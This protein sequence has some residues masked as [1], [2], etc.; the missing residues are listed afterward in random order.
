MIETSQKKTIK[1]CGLGEEAVIGE[2]VKYRR[3]AT[4]NTRRARIAILD[5]SDCDFDL[6]FEISQEFLG[7]VCIGEYD[8]RVADMAE[9][10]RLVGLFSDD[11]A[12][13]ENAVRETAILM[14]ST[15]KAILS[16]DINEL[17]AFEQLALIHTTDT[18]TPRQKKSFFG[19]YKKKRKKE[20]KKYFK[21]T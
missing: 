11:E 1:G 21:N 8:K 7:F 2:L 20:N 12:G 15:N 16:P 10:L 14:P 5:A 9:E 17:M 19:H 13:V 3:G 4:F 18:D 6:L